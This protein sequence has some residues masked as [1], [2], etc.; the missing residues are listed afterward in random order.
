M[1]SNPTSPLVL[2]IGA[3][4]AGISAALWLDDLDVPFRWLSSGP[5]GGILSRVHNRI[6][7]YPGRSYPNG[8]QVVSDLRAHLLERGLS[9]EVAN[10][11]GFNRSAERL[12]VSAYGQ[13][14]IRPRRVILATGTRYRTLGVPGE[15]EGLGEWIS[16]S[17]TGD[18][19]RFAGRPVAVVGG[20]DAGFE[21]ALR[22]AEQGCQVTLLLRSPEPRARQSFIAAVSAEERIRIAPI[23]SIIRKIEGT[24]EGCRLFI[25]QD[26]EATTL[27]V[28]A[29]FIRI[30]VE[31]RVPQG[32]ERLKL[33]QGG[34][35]IVDGEVRSSDRRIFAA[36]DV[37]STP[38]RSLVTAAAQGAIAARACARDLNFL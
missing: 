15:R 28:A 38:L 36:G 27:D 3:G 11:A 1:N 17:A 2:I 10:V 32:L 16:Q 18:G 21:N 7:D 34:F 8:L 31:P 12:A 13:E 4:M 14:L 26:G 22:L 35:L 5:L 29:L 30:G 20:G 23:P 24:D 6:D 25:D 9:P 33:D 37:T 19:A